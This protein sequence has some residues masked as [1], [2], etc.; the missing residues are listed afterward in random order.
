M[1]SALPLMVFLAFIPTAWE[2]KSMPGARVLKGRGPWHFESMGLESHS[3]SLE[4][5][6]LL[7][8]VSGCSKS[9]K[10]RRTAVK[11][12]EERS[13]VFLITEIGN[14]CLMPLHFQVLASFH[15]PEMPTGF[16]SSKCFCT[17]ISQ[18]IIRPLSQIG[19]FLCRLVTFLLV[20][21]RFYDDECF[22]NL[23]GEWTRGN[24]S[25]R[26]SIDFL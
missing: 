21:Y 23:S 13:F 3:L 17:V 7:L 24:K 14:Y 8:Y 4:G 25:F 1:C 20:W 6:F 10:F 5:T 15:C 9:V 26:V 22:Y 18:V 2:S 12:D 19:Y 16:Y 11:Y